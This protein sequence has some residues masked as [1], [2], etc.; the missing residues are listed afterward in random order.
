MP[1][2]PTP[3]QA[4][5]IIQRQ[6]DMLAARVS[7]TAR[8]LQKWAKREDVGAYRL[9]D[10]DI[11]EI[12]LVVDWYQGHLQVAEYA[13]RQTD[14]LPGWLEAMGAAVGQ[15][16]GVPPQHVHLKR[17]ETG[18]GAR[19][20]RLDRTGERLQVSEQGLRF[21]VN[22]SDYIDTGLFADHRLTRAWV[23]ELAKGGDFLNL[24]AYTGTFTCYAAAGGAERT[25]TVDLSDTYLQWTRENLE[26]NDIRGPKHTLVSADARTFLRDAARRERRYTLAL[27]DPPSYS[28]GRSG[29]AE[30]DVQRDHRQLVLEALA[31][32]APGGT[33]FFSTNHQRFEPDLDGLPAASVE[34][35]T[36]RTVPADYR[37]KQVHRCWKIGV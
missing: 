11:P 20:K 1:P 16:L 23:R 9:Y 26:L 25:T 33:L 5:Q 4:A 36:A 15:A 29:V 35:V 14:E 24:Y 32:L 31:V 18:Q 19:Y 7:K 30:F 27:L 10:W 8:N 12:R 34:D 22:L 21:W 6:A 28:A 2:R 17:R 37:N 13:R 3:H